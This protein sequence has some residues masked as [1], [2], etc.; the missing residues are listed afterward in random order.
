MGLL[1]PSAS[2]DAFMSDATAIS[3]M[4]DV[5]DLHDAGQT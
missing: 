1:M 2:Q 4:V 5:H 3:A